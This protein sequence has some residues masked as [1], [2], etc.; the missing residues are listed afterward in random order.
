MHKVAVPS[1][2][3]RLLMLALLLAGTLAPQPALAQ[4]I[5]MECSDLVVPS[6]PS[7]C[8]AVVYFPDPV[9][10]PNPNGPVTFVFRPPSGS[11]FPSES[12]DPS[13]P[14]T[15]TTNVFG[16][17]LGPNH[18]LL[19]TCTFTVTVR[20]AEA[21]E[22]TMAIA[23]AL[24]GVFRLTTLVV[25][26][27]PTGRS[28]SKLFILYSPFDNCGRFN[29]LTPALFVNGNPVTQWPA[30]FPFGQ[31]ILSEQVTDLAGNQSTCSATLVVLTRR[32]RLLGDVPVHQ[33]LVL[34]PGNFSGPIEGAGQVDLDLSRPISPQ[35]PS[36]IQ[37]RIDLR[38]VTVTLGGATYRATNVVARNVTVNGVSPLVF[39]VLGRYTFVA[40]GRLP[41]D[42][43]R[44]RSFRI[45]MPL[46]VTIT[47]DTLTSASFG[48]PTLLHPGDDGDD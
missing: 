8:G 2:V 4:A 43:I 33:T 30:I 1:A 41:P 13:H 16:Q 37:A 15:G 39:S 21:P 11:F 38:G 48:T 34:P 20:D 12:L 14:S 18:E 3:P 44:P 19:A 6:D 45:A 10:S 24:V 26:D 17:A 7:Q 47:G 40:Q 28:L 36:H 31:T 32:Q 46:N 23:D 22:C 35:E 29:L 9:L 27:A 25:G 42:P 5:S